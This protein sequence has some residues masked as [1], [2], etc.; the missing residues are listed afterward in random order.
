MATPTAGISGHYP[1][2]CPVRPGL[3]ALLPAG[4]RS[5]RRLDTAV[6]RRLARASGAAQRL[7]PARLAY[8]RDA[9]RLHFGGSGRVPSDGDPQL[10]G[11]PTITGA[12]LAGLAVLWLL[13]RVVMLT[14]ADLAL[15]GGRRGRC[16]LPAAGGGGHA[17]AAD[18]DAE[19]AQYRF[20]IV[21][22]LVA[23][24]NLDAAPGCGRDRKH[25]GG[26]TRGVLGAMMVILVV[27]GGRVIPF[28]TR[29][30]LPGAGA[31]QNK[32]LDT[33]QRPRPRWP[34]SCPWPRR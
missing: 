28:F 7:Q 2:A 21:L 11:K 32:R 20:P 26:V 33:R 1:G 27:M 6:G 30:R 19:P 18:G 23:L 12:P 17:A 9:V 15:A 24:A 8:A 16:R 22:M 3:P 5:C 14:G 31:G 10:D 25:G 13:G 34:P 29:N 4:G